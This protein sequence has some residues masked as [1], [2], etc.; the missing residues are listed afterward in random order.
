MRRYSDAI[1]LITFSCNYRV[2]ANKEVYTRLII[3]QTSN[4]LLLT[5]S[6]IPIILFPAKRK[7]LHCV[8]AS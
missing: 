7:F 8:T 5:V 6:Q 2:F 3:S 4:S 1:A